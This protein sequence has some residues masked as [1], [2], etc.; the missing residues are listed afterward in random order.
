MIDLVKDFKLPVILVA[1]NSLG[2][3][4]HTL[5][6][7]EALKRRKIKVLG[8]VF[9]RIKKEHDFIRKDNPNIVSFFAKNIK[10]WNL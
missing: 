9:N 8:V 3:I 6:T 2:T 4:N 5:L 10:I 1:E 7:L